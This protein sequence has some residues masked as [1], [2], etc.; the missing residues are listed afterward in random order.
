M[1][2]LETVHRFME[3]F[4]SG[5]DIEKLRPLLAEDLVFEARFIGPIR[6]LRIY[7]FSPAVTAAGNDL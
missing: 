4:Y 5:N 7:K 1:S 6:R 3:I 2:P